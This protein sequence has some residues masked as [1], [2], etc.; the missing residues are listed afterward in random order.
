MTLQ[1]SWF[2]DEHDNHVVQFGF[3]VTGSIPLVREQ[4]KTDT[5]VVLAANEMSVLMTAQHR[6]N[7]CA[8]TLFLHAYFCLHSQL[9]ICTMSGMLDYIPT[10]ML[11]A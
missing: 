4:M 6:I 5:F 3:P 1:T 8:S 9:L 11:Q 10:F 7:D 2:D